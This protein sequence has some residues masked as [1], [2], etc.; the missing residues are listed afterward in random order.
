MAGGIGDS[1]TLAYTLADN[2]LK[3]FAKVARVSEM[4]LAG[5]Y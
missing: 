4:A 5:T 1:G 3:A 2:A